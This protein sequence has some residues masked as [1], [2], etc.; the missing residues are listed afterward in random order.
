MLQPGR[1]HAQAKCLYLWVMLAIPEAKAMFN[2][3][4]I[5]DVDGDRWMSF[6][7]AWGR[8]IGFLRWAPGFSPNSDI[9]IADPV[10]HHDPFDCRKADAAA[11]ALFPLIY[12]GPLQKDRN[13][14]DS[15]ISP[16]QNIQPTVFPCTAN[17]SVGVVTSSGPPLLTNHQVQKPTSRLESEPVR[18]KPW[19]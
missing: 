14:D 17:R 16:G 5:A 8:P 19:K 15:G 6:V 18:C 11:Y 10:A 2:G 1:D 13:G 9:Q 3:V 12:A 7:D 4:E